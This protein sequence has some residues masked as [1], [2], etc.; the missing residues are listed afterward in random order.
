MSKGPKKG[1]LRV[2][3][4]SRNDSV[5]KS[6]VG[7]IGGPL[8]RRTAPGVVSPGFWRI[9]RVLLVLVAIAGVIAIFT[10]TTCRIN[11]WGDPYRYIGMCYS[12]WTALW[13]A[14]GFN[15]TPFAP[16][17]SG[18]EP[19]EYPAGMAIIASLVSLFVP[20]SLEPRQQSLLY[21]DI[22]AFLAVVLWAVV[23]IAVAKMSSR[24]I[25]DAAMVALS[26]AI[27]LALTVNWDMW[28][29]A[30]MVTGL[31]AV[32]REHPWLGG[33][34]IGIG[35][36][37]KLFPLLVLGAFFTLAWRTRRWHVFGKI[38]GGAG[39]GWLV[40]NL[41]V[42]LID[43]KRWAVF[44]TFSSDR[45]AG[46]SST[47]EL[48][49][50]TIGR[51]APDLVLTA[52]TISLLGIIFFGFWCLGV[53]ML[54]LI[55]PYRPR[56]A[57]L[58][59]LILAMFV[60]IGKVYSPQFVMWLVPLAVLAYPRWRAL[61]LW[62]LFE[63]F[64]FVAIWMRLYGMAQPDQARGFFPDWIFSMTVL[65][66]I[67]SLGAL[68]F[69]VIRCI[70]RPEEDPVRRV[71]LDDPLGG[72]FASPQRRGARAAKG[73]RKAG[74]KPRTSKNE[75]SRA[76]TGTSEPTRARA[77]ATDASVTRTSPTRASASRAASSEQGES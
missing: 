9:E 62:Q 33:I 28:A 17:D 49:N 3:V 50:M 51:S 66:H 67:A 19:F 44:Y 57:Q 21:F 11:G 31:F 16:F 39:I 47:W 70:L 37:V 58:S 52:D 15:E 18:Q 63:V 34:L 30:L 22:N 40:I 20:R 75:P 1:P 74:T 32:A 13:G 61:L 38:A 53:L 6:L 76:R 48:W 73:R 29:I 7:A 77:S 4:P 69:L 59:F 72:L 36:A 2:T 27:I 24:R 35:G 60:L 65:G 71:G 45:G 23:V 5:V 46:F 26:P 12:D 14:R 68:M 8:G 56:V 64:H 42:Y 41:P 55:A 10:K 25:W 43:P 54:G